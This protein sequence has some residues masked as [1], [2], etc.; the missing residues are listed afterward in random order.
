M[1]FELLPVFMDVTIVC[2]VVVGLI[3]IEYLNKSVIAVFMQAVLAA[4]L[5]LWGLIGHFFTTEDIGRTV[6]NIYM[7][8]AFPLLMFAGHTILQPAKIT[9]AILLII[10]FYVFCAA[11]FLKFGI[12]EI[13]S[14]LYVFSSFIVCLSFLVPFIVSMRKKRLVN[15]PLFVLSLAIILFYGTNIPFFPLAD[16]LLANHPDI[17]DTVFDVKLALN[18]LHFLLIASSFFLCRKQALLRKK[19]AT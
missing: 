13:G 3:C 2:A 1:D 5:E 14:H 12:D 11:T 4:M 9:R 15:N 18:S 17:R 7:L 10:F 8:I 6:D 19:Q 16:Y